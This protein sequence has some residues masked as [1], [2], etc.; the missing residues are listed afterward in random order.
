MEPTQAASGGDRRARCAQPDPR[1]AEGTA[2]RT[3]RN[4]LRTTMTDRKS[5]YRPRRKGAAE[6]DPKTVAWFRGDD[7]ARPPWSALLWGEEETHR[8]EW[9]A[10]RDEIMSDWSRE[11]PG[12][13]PRG[14]WRCEAPEPRRRLG[15]VGT[16]A[17]DNLH[18]GIPEYWMDDDRVLSWVRGVA[19]NPEN[20]PIFES[21][22]AYL[23]RLGLLASG[24][25]EQ[26]GP[27]DFERAPVRVSER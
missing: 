3:Q 1:G 4:R 24:E 17:S 22:A 5:T 12:S 19:L 15:G 13:R 2:P 27:S 18:L 7:N 26:L 9:A 21:E 8:R 25:R 14:W 10:C 11:H 23:E 20:P 16:A 6:M